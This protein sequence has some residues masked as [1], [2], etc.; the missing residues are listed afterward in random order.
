MTRPISAYAKWAGADDEPNE[1][2]RDATCLVRRGQQGQLHRVQAADLRCRSA[3][4]VLLCRARSWRLA[5]VMQGARGGIDIPESDVDRVKVTW[6]ST[7]AKMD[8]TPPW[9]D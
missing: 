8:R 3:A 2:Y 9:E 7:T 6:R 4:S 5:G 1:K